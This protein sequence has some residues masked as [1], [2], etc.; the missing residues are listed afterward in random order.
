MAATL[1][2]YDLETFGTHPQWD[3]IAQFAAVRTDGSF[4]ELEAPQ[5]LYCRLSPDY[6]PHPDSC[7][8]TGITPQQVNE[9][10]LSEREFAAAIHEAMSR[11]GTTTAGFNTIRFD[12]EFV[13]A[14]FYR[15]F[16]DPYGRE[17]QEGNAR[18]DIID[19]A[20]MCRDLRPDG[21]EW[22]TD[23]NGKPS[24]PLDGLAR[25]NGLEHGKVHDALSDVRATIA[26]AERI[27]TAQPKLFGYYF[28]LRKKDAVRKL[29]NLQAME[30]VVHTS[31]MFTSAA[32]CTTLVLPLSVHPT[33]GNVVVTYDLR[34]DP[35]DWID[36]PVE[37]IRRRVFTK[38]ED[39]ED[40]LRIPLKG[41]HLNRSPAVAP[42]N[43]LSVERAR[44][45]G[46]DVRRCLAHAETL[47]GRPDLV[48]KV[49]AV[50]ENP[51]R[52][53]FSDPELQIYSGD[54]FPDEDREEFAVIRNAPPEVLKATPPPLYDPRGPELLRRYIARNFPDSLTGEEERR[55]K[56]F[57][58]AR[59]L[60][61]EP[62]GVID[63]NTFRRE[64]AN[65][66][67]R[68]DTPAEDKRILK[69]LA[70]YGEYL[71]KTVLT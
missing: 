71:E 32:G 20:R 50:Y 56:S 53:H 61:P 30:P 40:D 55:W 42:R 11:P 10:G 28:G 44:A 51:P 68:L 23:E 26:L 7:L 58:A 24:F 69:A 14:L 9:G 27:H 5:V 38:R 13:R 62:E 29:L 63:F 48:Q 66:L 2:W 31:A 37:E 65:R 21:V 12:D 54:F 67:A 57:C 22:V 47:R 43:T 19:L 8:V 59:I 34:R 60:T 49:R 36:L 39:L 70:E 16:Y 18:W 4:R 52:R 3:R 46:I 6:L 25:A 1:L 41:I 15:N 33:Q 35:A 45:L 64:V 17:Y